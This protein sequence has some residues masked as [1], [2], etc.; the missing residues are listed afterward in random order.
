[1]RPYFEE[2]EHQI[3]A[4]YAVKSSTSKGKKFP[5]TPSESRTCFQHDR[6]RIVHS[7]SF[8]RLKHKTQ[9]FIATESDHYR[10][11]LTHS[12]EVAQI[13][14]HIARLLRLNEDLAEAIA[15]AHDLGHTPFG[16]SGEQELNR[17]MNPFGGF[18]HNSQSRRI[19]EEL[20]TK[21]PL[22]P[23][24]NLSFEV[25]EGLMKHSTPWDNPD[26]KSDHFTSLEAQV[27]NLADEI[28]Y[29]NHDLDDGLSSK[30]L[31]EGKLEANIELWAEA[32]KVI[33]SRY[34]QLQDHE[35]K[36][37]INSYLISTQI[38]DVLTTTEANIKRT[39]ITNLDDLQKIEEPLVTFSFDMK[40]KNG[41]LRKY[42]YNELYSHYSIYRMNKKGQLIIRQLFEL[43]KADAKLLPE[44]YR[45]KMAASDCPE[46]VVAD[47][48]AG[49]TDVYAQREYETLF[50]V[51][52]V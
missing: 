42:L 51:S 22:F 34:S 4:P 49:M 11:R 39:G 17:L 10:S 27:V 46:R 3:L 30:I 38:T 40:G 37:L 16:H 12:L 52:K 21:Y 48:I 8:R 6:D 35:L 14:R 50:Q 15:L 29:N 18:E 44:S 2:L 31:E 45:K 36:H 47:Y 43:F 13:S 28:A 7:K 41:Q 19:V 23:G 20:E 24:L 32:K 25:L 1:L 33:Q 26:T 9:V 5:E